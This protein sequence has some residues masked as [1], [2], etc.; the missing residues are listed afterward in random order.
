[1]VVMVHGARVR[2]TQALVDAGGERDGQVAQGVQQSRARLTRHAR[3]SHRCQHIMGHRLW[4]HITYVP[5]I[6]QL[7]QFVAKLIFGKTKHLNIYIHI[8]L[9]I[10]I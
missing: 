1:M 10:Y 7:L 6:L 3:L 9:N 8:K 5:Y 4:T 2:V